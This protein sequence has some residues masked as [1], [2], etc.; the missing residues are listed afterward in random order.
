MTDKEVQT[1]VLWAYAILKEKVLRQF[2]IYKKLH[3]LQA[4]SMSVFLGLLVN[5]FSGNT[6]N[7]P[8]W[9]ATG[10]A[11]TVS[12]VIRHFS[13]LNHD[14]GATPLSDFKEYIIAE[15]YLNYYDHRLGGLK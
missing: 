10:T 1:E 14:V 8:V 13:S 12:A 15:K 4:T 3:F 11:S 9:I 5:Y 2:S 6:I 7:T